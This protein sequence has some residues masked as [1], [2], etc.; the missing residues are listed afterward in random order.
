MSPVLAALALSLLHADPPAN[1]PPTEKLNLS[2][3]KGTFFAFTDGKK[4]YVVVEVEKEQTVPEWAFYGDGKS[5]YRLRVKGGGGESGVSWSLALWEPR[6][7]SSNCHLDYKAGKLKIGCNDRT[8]EL[9]RIPPDEGKQVID[10]ASFF[11]YRWTRQPYLL[12]RD[13]KGSYYFVDMERDV[14]GK[15]DMRLY[16]GPR[17]KLKLQQMTNIVSDSVGDIFSTKTGELR[18][19]ANADAM[20]WVQGKEELKL[21]KVPPEDNHIL[22]YTDLGVYERLPLGTPCD[23]F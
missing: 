9:T 10:A 11:S 21:T 22:I 6:T 1:S 3:L 17:G 5:M 4:H 20:K 8:T 14:P 15:K 7:I 18:L 12:A 19:V 23:D 16:I 2:D 13:D